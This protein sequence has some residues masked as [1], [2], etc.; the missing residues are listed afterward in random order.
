MLHS[1][2]QA[3]TT[4]GNCLIICIINWLE[5]LCSRGCD[6][7]MLFYTNSFRRISRSLIWSSLLPDLQNTLSWPQGCK[8]GS[9]PAHQREFSDT[10]FPFRCLSPRQRGSSTEGKGW[11]ERALTSNSIVKPIRSTV[12]SATAHKRPP[13][14]HRLLEDLT[15]K[16]GED[17]GPLT[18]SDGTWPFVLCASWDPECE[19]MQTSK[20]FMKRVSRVNK[21]E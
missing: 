21:E 4:R 11:S 19:D 15:Q 5:P 20:K 8:D 13:K 18:Y 12:L 7:R 6:Y 1:A 16:P 17:V 3:L 2:T 9:T 14:T 10:W